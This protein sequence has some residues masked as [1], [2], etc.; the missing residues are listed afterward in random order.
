[1][2]RL[3]P[4]SFRGRL[5]TLVVLAVAPLF[6]AGTG[7]AVYLIQT[8]MQKS[9]MREVSIRLAET[10][11]D[12]EYAVASARIDVLFLAATPPVG[13]LVRAWAHGGIDPRAGSTVPHWR[14][15]MTEI[16]SA[17]VATKQIYEHISFLDRQGREVVHVNEENGRAVFVPD[18]RLRNRGDADYFAETA[19]LAKGETYVS[20]IDR[21]DESGGSDL[22]RRPVLRV[23]TP[24][25]DEAGHLQGIV[26]VNL[27]V[28][29][30]LKRSAERLREVPGDVFI[31]DAQGRYLYHGGRPEK[32][33]GGPAGLNIGEGVKKDYPNGWEA[34]LSGKAGVTAVGKRKVMIQIINPWPAHSDFLA[35][36]VDSPPAAFSSA[37]AEPRIVIA[38]LVSVALLV[39]ILIAVVWPLGR[40]IIRP[41]TVLTHAVE[42]FKR[43][44]LKARAGIETEGE[45]GLLA[46]TFN[47]MAETIGT[48]RARLEAEISEKMA[49]ANASNRA[50]LS[51]MQDATAERQRLEKAQEELV[52][53]R[54][55]AEAASRAKSLFVANMSHEIRTPMNAILGFARVLERDPAI[56]P[57]QGEHVRIITRS[58]VH[59]LKLINDILDISKIEAGR[60]TLEETGYDLHDLLADLEKTFRPQA[61]AKGLRF[62]LE[63]EEN[64]PRYTR[65]DVGKLR[66]IFVNLIGNAIK[67]TETGGVAVRVRA[68]AVAG[69]TGEG[70]KSLRLVAEVE[71]SGPG[72]PAVERGRIFDAFQQ[73]ASGVKAGGTG[74]GLAISRRFVEMMGGTLTVTSRV[75]QGSCFRFEALL[76]PAEEG[77]KKT[78]PTFRRVVGLEPGAGPC[79]IL[80][81]DDMPDNRAL[82]LALLEPIGF[83]VQEAENGVE[84]L[85]A[86]EKWS[87]QAVLMDMR[88]PVMD[89]YEATRRIKATEAGRAIPIIAVTSS[90]FEDSRAQVIAAGVDG[91]L[92]KPFR[93][94]QLFEA[95]EKSLG[96][97]YVYLDETAGAP[98]DAPAKPL[99]VESLAALP[100]ELVSAMRQVV[101]EGDMARMRELIDQVEK[102][103]GV[104][105][106]G[107]QAL[108]DRY[109]YGKLNQMLEKGN[110]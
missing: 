78:M 16:W 83:E 7:V 55:A 71:D 40:S 82:L 90:A 29:E 3:W 1:M 65:G 94:E 4:T 44:D 70:K 48:E 103:D 34:I 68:E 33:W 35:V 96:L 109:D 8:D 42:R 14:G 56:T 69:Q 58:G 31:A 26:V 60:T 54:E 84:A 63:R 36:G 77:E 99:T 101:A 2:K 75:G 22:Y 79:R 66:Q 59:L 67:F 45:I 104:A 106:R 85:E 46:Q 37:F 5:T 73:A 10:S 25:F 102:I 28:L 17:A 76:T 80:A 41:L 110:T 15:R 39:L 38:I 23:T 18:D 81:V 6:L 95:L 47:G 30:V 43:G 74:L 21:R 108:A 98:V 97:R 13:G 62:L 12:I 19:R 64:A 57:Q 53:A 89:G 72:I 88:M 11:R 50:A 24:V 51:L 107:L 52:R 87:P 100:Q 27:L 61:E 105:A 20:P 92:I 9:R 32:V 93:P 91:L 86:F 49:G